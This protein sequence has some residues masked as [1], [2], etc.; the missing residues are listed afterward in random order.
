MRGELILLGGAL[1]AALAA[2]AIVGRPAKTPAGERDGARPAAEAPRATAVAPAA[3]PAPVPASAHAAPA[4]AAA[5]MHYPDG[6]T[7]PL[8]N[9]VRDPV[10]IAWPPGY[11]FAKVVETVTDDQHRQWYRHADGSW[12]TTIVDEHDSKRGIGLVYTP[13]AEKPTRLRQ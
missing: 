11:P 8:L 10:T 5:A 1:A 7:M 13:S 3:A 4:P 12:T 6:S 9:G 2:T